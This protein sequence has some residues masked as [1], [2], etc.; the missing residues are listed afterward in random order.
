MSLEEFHFHQPEV[1][2]DVARATGDECDT[3]VQLLRWRALEQ[4]TR[5]SH[6]FLADGEREE[7]ALT[8][9]ELDAQ[10]RAIAAM[11]QAVGATGERVLLLYPPGLQYIAAFFGCLY[12][13]AVAVPAYPP[14][15][16]RSLSR[17]QAIVHDARAIAALTTA[18]IHARATALTNQAPELQ[19][20]HWLVTDELAA[21]LAAD[22]R[23]P[24][25]DGNTLAFLQYTSGSTATPKGVMVSHQNLLSNERMIRQVFRQ[26]EQSFIVGWLPLYHDMGLIGNMLQPLYLGVPCALMSPL[27]FLQRPL[28]WLRAI[29]HYK[30]TT[31]GGPNF[32]Y[33]LCVNKIKPE[34]R[35]TLDLSSW[36]IAFNGAE[37]VRADTLER[38]AATFAASGFRRAAFQPCYGLAE[39]TLL[40]S[41]SRTAA[42]PVIKQVA[43]KGLEQHRVVAATATERDARSLVSCGGAASG[44]RVVIVNPD[45]L[46]ACAPDEVG[47][48]WVAGPGVAQGYWQRDAETE[49]VFQAH[50]ADTG[51]GPFLRTGD[52]GFITAGELFITGRRKDLI[53][54]RGLNYYPHDIEATVEQAHAQLRAGCGAAFAT[55]FAGEEQL[56]VVQ[57]VE[58]RPAHDWSTIAETVYQAVAHQHELQPHAI[59]LVK[60]GSIPKTSS[61]KLQRH[62]CQAQFEAGELAVV[63]EWRLSAPVAAGAQTATTPS[64]V[65]AGQVG[66]WLVAELAARL[67]LTH[68][69][70]D[71][72][73]P[74]TRYGIDS[75]SAVELAHRL[76]AATGISLPMVNFLQDAS[77]AQLAAEVDRLLAADSSTR[78]ELPT[79]ADDDSNEQQL[80]RGQQALWFLQ[81]LEPDNAAYNIARAARV[82]ADLDVNALQR[83]FQQLL[84]RHEALRAK[85][86][87][88]GREPV[89]LTH[90]TAQVCFQ[91]T[92]ATT[93]SEAAL[94]TQLCAEAHAPFDLAQGPLLRVQLF[95]R[96]AQ[97]HVLLLVV[98]HIV[99]DFWSLGVLLNELGLLYEAARNGTT[100]QLAPL[101]LRYVDYSRWQQRMLAGA[102]GQRLWAY[103]QQQLKGELPALNL[104]TDHARPPRQNYRGRAHNFKLNSALTQQLRA[105]ARAHDATFY[106][107]LLAGFQVLLHRY[108]GQTDIL[109]GS[110]AAGRTHAGFAPLVGYFVNPL[111]MRGDLTGEP[112]FAAFLARVR[113]TA[114]DAFT[115]Q[116]YPF[117]LLV[118]RLQPTRDPSRSPLFQVMFVLQN[119]QAADDAQLS[120]FALGEPGIVV[121]HGG[122]TFEAEPLEQRIAQFDLTLSM[123]EVG[124]G[125]A[126][127]FEYNTDLFSAETIARMAGHFRQL[128][129]EIAAEPARPV[130]HYEML[131]QA[132]RTRLLVE[133]NETEQ[134]WPTDATMQQLFEAQVARTPDAVALVCGPQQLTYAELHRRARQLAQHLRAL[135]VG[136]EVPVG[137]CVSRSV[138]LVVGLLGILQAGGAYVPLDP[139]YPQ[140]RVAFMLADAQTPVVLTETALL[141][142]LP[143]TGARRLCLDQELSID[144]DAEQTSHAQTA[145]PIKQSSSALAY[146]IYTSGSTGRPKGVAIEHRN[147][148]AMIDWATKLF[149]PE[150]LAGVLASTSICFDLSVFE[151]FVP[152]S[153]GGTI[154]LAENALHL[155]TLPAA[156]KVTLINTV[157][158][159]MTELVRLGGVPASVRTVNLAGEP[160]KGVLV[161]QIYRQATVKEVYNLY[162]PSEDTT[163]STYALMARGDAHAPLIGQP[164]A[165]SQCYILDERMQPV[166]LGVVGELY[167][168]GAGVARGYLNRPELTAEKF[169]PDPFSTSHGARLYKTGDLARRVAD[170]ALDFLGR[171][172]SQ[173]K[174]RGYRIELG[175]IEAAL[176]AHASVL[177]AAV[178]ARAGSGDD[179]RLVGYVVSAGA[180]A[181]DLTTLQND[182]RE[183]LPAYMMPTAWVVLDALPL[184]PNGKID[185]RA[186]PEP[187]SATTE[188]EYVAPRT[189]VEEMVAGVWV[190]VLGVERVGVNDNFFDLGGHSLLAT[191]VVARLR[192]ACNV[193]LPL[194]SMFESPTVAQLA[195]ELAALIKAEQGEQAPPIERMPR[196]D[197]LPLSFGQERLWFLDQL[198]PNSLAYNMSAGA[199]L[200]GRLDVAALARSLNE[201]VRR[202]EA[203]RTS[204]VPVNDQPQQ[205]VADN[206]TLTL[207]VEDVPEQDEQAQQAEVLRVAAEEARH[208]F[209]LTKAP[210]LKVRLLKLSEVEH[211]LLLTTHH[212]V[213]DGWSTG[214]FINELAALYEAFSVNE[215]APLAELPVQYADFAVWQRAWLQ[216]EALQAQLDYWQRQLA[217]A[218]PVI[219]LPLDR[220]RPAMQTFRGG[221]HALVVPDELS[222]AIKELSRSEGVTLF[223]ALLAGFVAFLYRY[224][225]QETIVV[226]TPVAN[227]SRAEVEGLIGFFVNT[228]LLRTDLDGDVTF[229]GL[230]KHVRAVALD[231][232]AHQDV[233][234]EKLVE[235]LQP[236]RSLSHTPLFQVMLMLDNE[237]AE[238][239]E[240]AGLKLSQLQSNTGTAKFDLSL[241]LKD[242]GREL[243]GALEYNCDLFDSVTIARMTGHL[244]N[245]F[246]GAVTNPDQKLSDLPLLSA[247]EAQSLLVDWNETRVDYQDNRAVH[248]LIEAQAAATPDAVAVEFGAASLSFA[249]LNARANQVAQHLRALGVGPDV[250]VGLCVERSIEMVVGLLGILKAGGAYVPL[251]PTY[252]QERLAFMLAD[253][254][255]PVLLTQEHLVAGLPQHEAA[256]VCLDADW[257]LIGA[258]PV[259]N[260][261]IAVTPENL[262][263][264]IYTSGSTG[265]PKGVLVTH[266]GLSN[267]LQWSTR[268]YAVTDGQGAPVHSSLSFDLTVTSLFA[269]LVVGGASV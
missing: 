38:F 143:E 70:V 8:Y 205:V 191:Q 148:V 196:A 252:P 253:A 173:V 58:L 240:F 30:A 31:S 226:G 118:E 34:D 9:A 195:G 149:T 228:L 135:G 168:G 98:H 124:D 10:A 91:T 230:L 129:E 109:V 187:A 156:D 73:Q 197:A 199:R 194:R 127:V 106:M 257:P 26:T 208:C 5:R 46:V 225:Q 164:I 121:E 138:E 132:E 242:T 202:H 85:F 174:I 258:R 221:Q 19:R 139:A 189:T 86:V 154:I 224:T 50:R 158:S 105:L 116:D 95:T 182:L 232:Y 57:E 114:L 220:P 165:N 117:P 140:E 52:L 67:G 41:G 128:L 111:V 216:G 260:L 33:E 122:L 76:E 113:E 81:Q 161:Q 17:L 256:V 231:A 152:L 126:A 25:I 4:P 151:L 167:I 259:E 82:R 20:L 203:L 101:A 146:V 56:V 93:W 234:F 79:R 63:H 215:P 176:L 255:I 110:P 130:S 112:T 88:A 96:G 53:I 47:E 190:E 92:D 16:N 77:V 44:Q 23:E 236:E 264:V 125:L 175:E 178:M 74:L 99:A 15:M 40:V 133:W 254:Q 172:D 209:D 263:Y 7:A 100:A 6:I 48:I 137:V 22:W 3:L 78:A 120:A 229:R 107:T 188:Q 223:M 11:L 177:E 246:A 102:A 237:P 266:G 247:E 227:R 162:G 29:A 238:Q 210:L 245:L 222:A 160:L 214:V 204:F 186:L 206:I 49:R 104:P 269:P 62:L 55:T 180:G 159:A 12:A 157:P 13:G 72:N 217:G 32:A 39:A 18:S 42:E 60:P 2:P 35:A 181:L 141:D 54:I 75:L 250:A 153:C 59:V 262:A 66:D 14:R 89:L 213:W 144:A 244:L 61:G 64:L 192:Q 170:G 115:H 94:A 90:D 211:V 198:E 97:E 200:E 212:I 218:P 268:A 27:A 249:E 145:A 248:Q 150:Q 84:D 71:V 241:A 36:Q 235:E 261:R 68:A 219:E 147:A 21:G 155:P 134:A 239:A 51:E 185:R 24:V 28:R 123:A 108:T 163:Y 169:I 103:W 80:S 131:P 37:P 65:N 1:L 119:M 43:A 83:A 87:A 166:P 233:P 142:R 183:R 171:G 184:T 201:I 265:R 69:Q 179:I 193:D 243:I 136:P 207:N 251:D 45:T 267:Y